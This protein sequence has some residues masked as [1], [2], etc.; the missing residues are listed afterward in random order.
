MN[1]WAFGPNDFPY[2]C[3]EQNRPADSA[4]QGCKFHRFLAGR[5]A[6]AENVKGPRGGVLVT[7]PTLRWGEPHGVNLKDY[8]ISRGFRAFFLA[9]VRIGGPKRGA[10]VW[11]GQIS[12][13]F[14]LRE[15]VAKVKAAGASPAG[16]GTRSRP[17]RRPIAQRHPPE[18]RSLWWYWRAC[19]R[20]ASPDNRPGRRFPRS[21]LPRQA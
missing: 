14:C 7:N 5:A 6:P 9:R 3:A 8:C 21:S 20:G 10:E 2:F 1:G 13:T 15:L 11:K 12:R 16:T 19:W 18:P 4:E 17:A